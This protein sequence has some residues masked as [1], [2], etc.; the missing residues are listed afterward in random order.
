MAPA[1]IGLAVV[2]LGFYLLPFWEESME[3]SHGFF[4]P[5]LSVWLLVKSRESPNATWPDRAIG[6]PLRHGVGLMFVAV[7]GVAAMAALAQGVRH[8]QTA[9]LVTVAGSTFIVSQSI[10]ASRAADP[11]IRLNGASLAAAALW[12]FAVPLPSGTLSRLTL[13][14]Q[15]QLSGIALST[16]HLLGHPAER[17]GTVLKI[18]G[19]L[20]GVED[21]CSGVISLIACL[22]MGVFLGGLLLRNAGTRLFL[23]GA[24]A[25][26]AIVGNVIRTVALCLLVARGVDIDGAW[27]DWSGLGV[28]GLTTAGLLGV[29]QLFE[30]RQ[31]INE[32]AAITRAK[33]EPRLAPSSRPFPMAQA[34]VVTLVA[35][36]LI[37]VVYWRQLPP[38]DPSFDRA[39]LATLLD[40]DV[41]GWEP[42]AGNDVNRFAGQLGTDLLFQK[43]YQQGSKRIMFYFAYWPAKSSTLGSVGLHTPDICLPGAGWS[44]QPLPP[45]EPP[46]P[47]PD[48]RRYAFAMGDSPVYILF[49]HFFGGRPVAEYDGLYP[50]QLAP[51]ILNR[52]VSSQ[53]AQW[54][55]RVSSNHPVE[56]SLEEPLVKSLLA[57][58]DELG[59]AQ[60]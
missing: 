47:F 26:L 8:S 32:S 4:A 19:H 38:A 16:L 18:S 23:I 56:P 53:A 27:H 54:I 40:L 50:W 5:I 33:S 14:L 12:L 55:L 28:L 49:W 22:F 7:A 34:G 41:P 59:L 15:D 48:V 43:T 44:P 37:G 17:M 3:L 29:C 51:L 39:R 13:L 30:R 2:F 1:F 45:A 57:R 11:V 25:L 42:I 6:A 58:I 36:G 31:A 46:Y 52:P 9:F 20:V 10:V 21:A 60:P 24:A 35:L